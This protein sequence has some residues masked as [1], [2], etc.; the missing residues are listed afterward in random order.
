MCC[1]VKSV[2]NPVISVNNKFHPAYMVNYYGVIYDM[3]HKNLEII[4]AVFLAIILPSLMI[5]LIPVNK[6]AEEDSETITETMRETTQTE[7]LMVSVLM[8]DGAVETMELDQYVL[9]VV[10]REMPAEFEKEALK[11]QAVVA[12]T[13]ALRRM[14]SESKHDE[15]DICS[16]PA[17]CQ[18]YCDP[19]DFLDAGESEQVLSKV[20]TAVQETEGQVLCYQ[21]ELIEATYF[22][23]SGGITEDAMAVWGADIPYLRSVVSPGEEGATHFTD[24][25]TFTSQE[26]NEKLGGKFTGFPESWVES[27]TYTQGGG[28][29][30]IQICG[31]RY[32]GTQLRNLLSLRS[33][34][35]AIHIVA[36]T[37]TITTKGFGHR[38]GMSQYGAEAMAVQG[39]SY[40]EI[41]SHYYS[42]T[43]L[44]SYI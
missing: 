14:N 19:V 17:C 33:T 8:D 13:Y 37:V 15:A 27:V 39:F 28:V 21:G 36:D 7:K 34:A 31:E 10:L 22:S 35:F 3:K 5:T 24:K 1:Y 2:A 25:V 30:Q 20:S 6:S 38:V 16:S 26:F 44:N 23:C 32:Q 4:F 12:R 11:A 42:G 43:V 18:G 9:G 40:E 29:D 41:L